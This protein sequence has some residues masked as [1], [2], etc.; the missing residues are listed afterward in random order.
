MI[1]FL[2]NFQQLYFSFLKNCNLSLKEINEQKIKL[3]QKQLKIFVKKS[4]RNKIAFNKWFFNYKIKSY[5]KAKEVEAE[6]LFHKEFLLKNMLEN[7]K[8]NLV[9]EEIMLNYQDVF[10]KIAKDEMEL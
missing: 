4:F 6:V 9:E 5:S 3:F 10:N 1:I 7:E 8:I 2:Q